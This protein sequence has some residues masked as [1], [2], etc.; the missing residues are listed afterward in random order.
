MIIDTSQEFCPEGAAVNPGY[1]RNWQLVKLPSECLLNVGTAPMSKLKCLFGKLCDRVVPHISFL[2]PFNIFQRAF[3]FQHIQKVGYSGLWLGAWPL[4]SLTRDFNNKRVTQQG[5]GR[6]ILKV[7]TL[8][9]HSSGYCV[10]AVGKTE[11]LSMRF[12]FKTSFSTKTQSP[13]LN[14]G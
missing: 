10:L 2:S 12:I 11:S 7:L 3:S 9:M 13:D 5:F 8:L 6:R 4:N 1:I 14:F